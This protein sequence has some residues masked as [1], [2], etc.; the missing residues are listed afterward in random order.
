VG[1]Q[2]KLIFIK[3]NSSANQKPYREKKNS[4]L[5]KKK[6]GIVLEARI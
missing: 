6:R 4:C 2:N 1:A 5:E 3:G